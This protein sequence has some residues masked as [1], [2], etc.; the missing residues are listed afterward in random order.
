MLSN[1]SR[2]DS[3]GFECRL[4]LSSGA[5]RRVVRK[6]VGVAGWWAVHGGW[7]DGETVHETLQLGCRAAAA[8]LSGGCGAAVGRLQPGALE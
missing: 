6:R 8:R 4:D 2:V 5:A 7:E 1:V 3:R